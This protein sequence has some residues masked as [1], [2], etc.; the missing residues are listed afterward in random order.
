M[1]RI[2]SIQQIVD[3]DVFYELNEN[4]RYVP[5]EDDQPKQVLQFRFSQWQLVFNFLDTY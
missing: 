4:S 2:K 5:G 3:P 1:E